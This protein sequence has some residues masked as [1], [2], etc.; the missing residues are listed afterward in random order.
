MIFDYFFLKL[1]NGV[2]RASMQFPRF[3]ASLVLGCSVVYYLLAINAL[4]AKSDFLPFV[5]NKQ[6]IVISIV[7]MIVSLILRYKDSRIEAMKLKFASDDFKPKKKI[8]NILFVLYLVLAL[9]II[10]PI[11]LYKPGYLPTIFD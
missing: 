10:I 4:L 11:S 8:L 5:F 7:I 1:Y 6:I 3:G 9:Y 2:I